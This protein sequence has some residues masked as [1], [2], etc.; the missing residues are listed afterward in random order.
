MSSNFEQ[1][2]LISFFEGFL[3][4]DCP[5]I[6]LVDIGCSG[7]IDPLWQSVGSKLKAVGVDPLL[8]TIETLREN[9]TNSNIKYIAGSVSVWVFAHIDSK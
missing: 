3:R 9:N 1:G 6:S 2:L 4:E 7:D 5:T 8:E